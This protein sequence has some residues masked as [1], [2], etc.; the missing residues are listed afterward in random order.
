MKIITSLL[1]A[2]TLVGCLGS[3]DTNKTNNDNPPIKNIQVSYHNN[4]LY[5][6]LQ[7][8]ADE[9]PDT[10]LYGT[11]HY[12][13]VWSLIE[14][15]IDNFQIGLPG[16]WLIP[17]NTDNKVT[18]LCPKDS[19]IRRSYPDWGPTWENQF[20]TIEGS[21]G[22]WRS[23]R[24]KTTAP[25]YSMNSTPDCYNTEV[26]TPGWP[27]FHSARPLAD[28]NLGLAQLSNRMLM[29]P[30]GLPYNGSPQGELIGYGYFALPLR[31]K[32]N[33]EQKTGV[34]HWT[35]FLNSLNFKGPLA[36]YLPEMWSKASK[37]YPF[38]LG[39]G[40][41]SR[42]LKNEI[43]MA[44]EVNTVD[45]YQSTDNAG[46]RY[47]KIP[48]IQ[49]P[50]D[51]DGKISLVKDL[52]YYSKQALFNTIMKWRD[53]SAAPSSQISLHHAYKP[54][55]KAEAQWYEQDNKPITDFN[56]D[57]SLQV[58]SDGSFGIEFT[59]NINENIGKL[60]RYFKHE[61][62]K[63]TAINEVDVPQETKLIE[64]EFATASQDAPPYSALPLEGSWKSP[65]PITEQ[66][67]VNLGD[68]T[69]ITYVWYRFIDQPVFQQYNWSLDEKNNLQALVEK[70]HTHW[71]ID[72]EYLE[73]V[74]SGILASF[75]E[76]L[77]VTP[78]KGLEVGYVPIVVQQE[79][80]SNGVC[81]V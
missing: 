3:S 13:P 28:D 60:P 29:P 76:G 32:P 66:F 50:L 64:Q 18:A 15:P 51:D 59:N 56:K 48:Q 52:H 1:V 44:M 7:S 17:D 71:T 79:L 42:A 22:Y 37:D 74:S 55:L 39:R 26:A 21:S 75:D 40:L 46:L 67:T 53:G 16:T 8:S 43:A 10:Y 23:S 12:S 58:F 69:Q 65:G 36:F 61:N 80:A 68:C 41:D 70:I 47:S 62:N 30:D 78:P 14:K 25:K 35:L 9:I 5:T 54:Q 19:A 77:I 33:N 73:P 2:T 34:Q 24:F 72:K 63:I 57:F 6:Y 20:Q 11:S 4:G 31:N 38:I 49:F 81:S 45:Q 27:F